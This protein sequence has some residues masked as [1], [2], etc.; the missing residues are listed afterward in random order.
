[1]NSYVNGAFRTFAMR[2]KLVSFTLGLGRPQAFIDFRSAIFLLPVL[3]G[4]FLLARRLL[5]P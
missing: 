3:G 1:M 2:P 4:A 5:L